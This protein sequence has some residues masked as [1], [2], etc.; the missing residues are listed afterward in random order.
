MAT[1]PNSVLRKAAELVESG[2][3]RRGADAWDALDA[4]AVRLKARKGRA[5]GPL[6]EAV[7]LDTPFDTV[8]DYWRHLRTPKRRAAWLRKVADRK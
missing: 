8:S 1:T 5:D 2:Q 4:A 3:L 6:C 7:Y